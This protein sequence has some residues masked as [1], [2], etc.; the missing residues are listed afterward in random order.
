[1]A[2]SKINI[3]FTNDGVKY[4]NIEAYKYSDTSYD[5]SVTGTAK[6]IRQYIDTKYPKF[7]GKGILWVKSRKFA[8]GNAID[9]YF[10][11]LPEEY[12][13]KIV[14]ELDMFEYYDGH[15]SKT[16]TLNTSLGSITIGTKYL[17]VVNVPPYDSKEKGEP[18]PDWEKILKNSTPTTSSGRSSGRSNFEWGDLV[19]ECAGWKL[20]VKPYQE[21]YVY[22]LV[23]DKETPQN[24]QNWGEIQGE[25]TTQT[26][27]KWTKKTQTFSKWGIIYDI[28][29]VSNKLCEI[30]LKYYTPQN[31]PTPQPEPIPEPTPTSNL[32]FEV[33][34]KW[35]TKEDR[36]VV[37]E[38]SNI[39]DNKIYLNWTNKGGDVFKDYLWL[40]E[41]DA[42]REWL[43]NG[44]AEIIE[45]K[46]T[47]TPT[48]T[49]K[50]ETIENQIKALT[51]VLKYASTDKD[52]KITENQINALKITLKYAQ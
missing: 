34:D 18:A 20:Y 36:S 17:D 47:T 51:L 52:K 38:V 7:S 1:M 25:I 5:I 10:N 24:R 40:F 50:K 42:N 29:E 41:D 6:M 8:N 39:I 37:Y 23:K 13:K 31:T 28:V 12:F 2:T 4:K 44:K 11:R 43:D 16:T 21:T 48:Y 3:D 14:K 32:K 19:T 9:V 27:F 30:L 35:V 46:T 49:S 15:N 45:R 33:G 26:G 22:N